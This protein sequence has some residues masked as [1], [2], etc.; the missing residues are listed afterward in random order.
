VGHENDMKKKKSYLTDFHRER[1][2]GQS[3]GNNYGRKKGKKSR[4][5][6]TSPVRRPCKGKESVCEGIMLE[7]GKILDGDNSGRVALNIN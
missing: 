5:P 3:A 6:G 7:S 4:R 1:N 2:E